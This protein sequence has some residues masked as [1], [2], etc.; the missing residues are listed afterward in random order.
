V[1]AQKQPE[2]ST[3]IH[4]SLASWVFGGV[5]TLF[6]MG[7]FVFG[8]DTLPEF[9]QRLLA[10]FCA[11]LAGLFGFFLTGDLAVKAE[12]LTTRFGQLKVKAGGG[13]ALFVLMLIWWLSP[14]APVTQAI[15]TIQTTRDVT[16]ETQ[17]GNNYNN[18][19]GNITVTPSLNKDE[20]KK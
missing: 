3:D 17:S 13:M 11:L 10:L 5:F 14:L 12:S 4:L 8:P 15:S 9:K 7:V 18:V 2:I 20:N 6:L 16:Q 1:A 19:I